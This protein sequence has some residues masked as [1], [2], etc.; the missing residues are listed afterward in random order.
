MVSWTSPMGP[1]L[2]K[3]Q[4]TTY[5]TYIFSPAAKWYNNF[6]KKHS[7]GRRIYG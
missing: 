5:F 7:G 1:P 3:R 2:L 4:Q 6:N